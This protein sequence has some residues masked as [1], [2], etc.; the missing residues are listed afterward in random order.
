MG[1]LWVSGRGGG[2][3]DKLKC[4]W[5]VQAGFAQ[6]G[7]HR[8]K[9]HPEAEV[10]LGFRDTILVKIKYLYLLIYIRKSG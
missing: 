1:P 2:V 5:H 3:G 8:R 4:L 10:K 6:T 9:A 7:E